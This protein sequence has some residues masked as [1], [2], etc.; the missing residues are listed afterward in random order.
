M[1]AAEDH[2]DIVIE[3]H[4][5][6]NY[7]GV[8]ITLFVFTILEVGVSYLK[9]NHMF[10]AVVLIGLAIIKACL[11]AWFFMHLKFEK[12]FLHALVVF[13]LVLAGVMMFGLM[14]DIGK[15]FFQDVRPLGHF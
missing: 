8:F 12:K 7:F 1:K 2:E 9:M 11:V 14:P 4:A 3:G 10:M 6:P 13:S 15:V 5:E